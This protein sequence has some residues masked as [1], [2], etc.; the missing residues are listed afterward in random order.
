MIPAPDL[1]PASVR[2]FVERHGREPSWR[3]SAPGRVNLV[4][5]H[6]DY[7]GGLCL[8]VALG[9]RT[10]V[11]A[12]PR[13]DSR[14]HLT[15]G[16]AL[17][18]SGDTSHLTGSPLRG[19]ASYVVGAL[20][21]VGWQGGLDLHV[22][23]SVPVGAGLSSSAALICA[24]VTAVTER[25]PDDL[26]RAALEAEQVHVGAP[27]GGMDQT[28]SLLARPAHALLLDFAGGGLPAGRPVPWSPERDGVELL[29]VDTGVRHANDDGAF[30]R[31]RAEAEAAMALSP[32]EVVAARDP[33]PRRRRHVDSEND[34]VRRVV[35]AVERHDWTEVGALFTASHVS[36]R[37][38][39]EVSCVEL[40]A[41]V[42]AART[43]GALGAR[44]T[45]G[46]FGGCAVVLVPT[47]QRDRVVARVSAAARAAGHPEPS[48][49]P[50]EAGGPA[51]RHRAAGPSHVDLS[52]AQRLT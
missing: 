49:L 16:D 14:V 30:A 7:L 47:T 51:T 45:G 50:G 33:L 2:A 8:P 37:D 18:W 34:R 17:E 38:D 52:Q 6:T 13:T 44:M 9:H 19:W 48:F 15:S 20:R 25:S 29:V 23:S 3:A 22:E 32:D 41:V 28:V 27:T 10:W 4:G 24:V 5:E 11:V 42:E 26:L 21:A 46:G 31:R 1:L 40:D 39:H 43:A 36:L 35:A 12:A